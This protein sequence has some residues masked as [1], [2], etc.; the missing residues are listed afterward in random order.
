MVAIL[1][2]I[3]I[4]IKPQ[5]RIFMMEKPMSSQSSSLQSTNMSTIVV[6]TVY[7]RRVTYGI[8]AEQDQQRNGRHASA[9][10]FFQR[11]GA[12]IVVIYFRHHFLQDLEQSPMHCHSDV[13]EHTN[14]IRLHFSIITGFN[15]DASQP[16]YSATA[17]I[18]LTI[19]SI[20]WSIRKETTKHLFSNFL[21]S[22]KQKYRYSLHWCLELR[23]HPNR[24]TGT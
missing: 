14:C 1:F 10:P 17:I 13:G 2:D 18:W 4:R 22:T 24:I 15:S 20:S 11:D 23:C 19:Q 21:Q 8:E 9:F 12:I 6:I 5:R 3:L 16:R 7:S